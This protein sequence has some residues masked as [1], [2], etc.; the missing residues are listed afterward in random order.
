MKKDISKSER[1][2]SLASDVKQLKETAAEVG[3]LYNILFVVWN[4]LYIVAYSVFI[5]ITMSRKNA[6]VE[7]LPY[8]LIAF[9]AAYFVAF[10]VMLILG[11]SKASIKA[12]VKN[13]KST[14]KIIKLCFKL[15]N[16]LLT[17]S[18]VFNAVLNDRSLFSII[19]AA[20]S[21]P[22]VIWQIISAIRKMVKR[23]RKAKVADQKRDLRKGL[24]GDVKGIVKGDT[25][26]PEQQNAA[27]PA[28]AKNSELQAAA[29]V[30]ESFEP[31]TAEVVVAEQAPQ[32]PAPKSKAAAKL[33]EAKKKAQAKLDSAKAVVQKGGKVVE[34]VKRYKSD[35]NELESGKKKKK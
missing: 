19:L 28:D 4:L 6:E 23:S 34:R 9:T 2:S 10:V 17:I 21:V 3:K 5:V 26:A 35:V 29:S 22:Y 16:L 7:W 30:Q 11:R 1:K 27:Q 20:V 25:A 32:T 33:D 18:M 12:S 24:I 31:R 14:F 8:L 15:F 13:Y